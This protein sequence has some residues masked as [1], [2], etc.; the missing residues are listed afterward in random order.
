MKKL[1]LLLIFSPSFYVSIAQDN[2]TNNRDILF[3]SIINH[4]GVGLNIESHYVNN[5]NINKSDSL[6]IFTPSNT[7]SLF[8]R[9]ADRSCIFVLNNLVIA[10]KFY[11][12]LIF[13]EPKYLGTLGKP[14]AFNR[15]NGN[16][17]EMAWDKDDFVIVV[18]LHEITPGNYDY[19]Y[20]TVMKMA[21]LSNRQIDFIQDYKLGK[22]Q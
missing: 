6:Y 12:N 18:Q 17:T 8:G 15:F 21:D 19:N 4:T 3:R 9:N 22:G 10:K 5:F 20:V 2:I 13:P 7:Q 14:F 11:F 16:I 1:F